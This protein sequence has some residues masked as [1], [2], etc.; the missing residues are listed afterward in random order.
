MTAVVL[1]TQT[2][3]SALPLPP[4][5]MVHASRPAPPPWSRWQVTNES[6]FGGLSVTSSKIMLVDD[7]PIV[8][9]VI[10]RYLKN[11]GYENFVT[12]S[13][14][15]RAMELIEQEQPDVVLLDIMMPEINGLQLLQ[16][17]RRQDRLRYLPVLMLSAS[18][19]D[20][21]RLL[22]LNLGATD[23]L[24]KPVQ[25]TELAPRVRN[26][27]VLKS[28]N[29]DLEEQVHRRTLELEAAR[30]E[31]IEC[32]A[33][34]SEYRD[35]D[36][37]NHVIRVGRFAAILG[38]ALG[39]PE[40]HVEILEQAALL[41]DVG[42]IGIPDAILLK[43]GKLEPNEFDFMKRHCEFGHGILMPSGISDRHG[44]IYCSLPAELVASSPI[45]KMA[46]V[47]AITHH[48]KWDGTG[49]PRGLAGEE[50]PIEG[51]IT[52]V[53]DVYD[54]LSSE[55]PYKRAFPR[56]KCLSILKEGR[57][58][59]FDPLVIDAFFAVA[60][61]IFAVQDQYADG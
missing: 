25:P 41:H 29:D 14:A 55:R 54:A 26:A 16:Q 32:L 18:G 27:L 28:H 19:D 17:I 33:R 60:H 6:Q 10:C 44:A 57:G 51:R 30:R 61:D 53:A 56:E 21:T 31:A 12:T 47:I 13:D 23:F 46:A 34:A 43:P 9:R 1:P 8:F 40:S 4:A 50:I 52:A 5:E 38:G 2:D 22:A 48:E 7:E 37:G 20:D 49:Y 24:S 15:T 36:T 11:F 45:M 35:D 59:H 3:L 58:A 39:L 42:K